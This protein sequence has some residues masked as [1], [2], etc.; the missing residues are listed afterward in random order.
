M[1]SDHSVGITWLKNIYK[2]IAKYDKTLLS[3]PH[4]YAIVLVHCMHSNKHF[5]APLSLYRSFSRDV[6]RYQ[7]PKLKRHHSFYPHQA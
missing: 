4:M 2:S 5:N 6:I 7:N 3:F 1:R